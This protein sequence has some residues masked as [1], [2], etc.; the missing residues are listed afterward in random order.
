MDLNLNIPDMDAENMTLVET[1]PAKAEQWLAGLPLLNPAETSYQIYSALV[2]LNRT[3]L[4]DK[5]RFRLLEI[6][7]E[8][9]ARLCTE[10]KGEYIG[11]PL[12][13]TVKGH[14]AAQRARA[15]QVEMAYGYKRLVTNTIE[16]LKGRPSTRAMSSLAILLQRA[17]RYLGETLVKSYQYYAQPPDNTWREIHQLA[18]LADAYGVFDV[19]VDDPL[20]T[21]VPQSSVA[22]VYKQALLVDFS[23]PYHLP[24]RLV[25]LIQHYLNRWASLA[26]LGP[27]KPSPAKNCQFLIDLHND[28]A[29]EVMFP[30]E[31]TFN[32][33]Q[34]RMLNTVELAKQIHSHLTMLRK[35]EKPPTEGLHADFFDSPT[36]VEMLKRLLNAWGLIPKRGFNRT[37]KKGAHVDVAIGIR[38]IN[39]WL[40]GGRDFILSSEFV[41]PMPQRRSRVGTKF[42]DTTEIDLSEM[43][44]EEESQTVEID[45]ELIYASWNIQD[46]S[47]G[48]LAIA[49]DSV[50]H[51]QAR[52]GD[53]IAVRS[54]EE[55]LWEVNGIRWVKSADSGALSIGMKRISPI[56]RPVMLKLN[57]GDQTET[58]FMPAIMVPE[59]K[60]LKQKQG[61]LTYKGSYRPGRQFFFDDGFRLAKGLVTNLVEATP[62][63]EHFEYEEIS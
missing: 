50:K 58:D 31:A 9:I 56:A 54:S 57:G 18:E 25:E 51:Q 4:D 17:I 39:H 19:P 35:G 8:P 45:P 3:E 20:N 30:T 23:D 40:N 16:S 10:L 63:F 1:K 37:S 46:E 32:E 53:L 42:V 55:G 6:Y 13:L 41:G 11:L 61:L 21:T 48:G 62:V 22:H 60:A 38:A 5:T 14:Q 15:L 33:Q 52:V 12:P 2:A 28:R 29:G 7:R 34:Y 24:V 59:L 26:K 47:A 49:K 43:E 27:A 36:I 44:T